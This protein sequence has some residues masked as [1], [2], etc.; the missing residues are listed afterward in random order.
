MNILYCM[1]NIY[2]NILYSVSIREK[3]RDT[4]YVVAFFNIH[5]N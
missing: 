5:W 3:K 4:I 2:M 1:C